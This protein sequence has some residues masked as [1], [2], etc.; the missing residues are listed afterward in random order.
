M[1]TAPPAKIFKK[2]T[3]YALEFK[4][5]KKKEI[6]KNYRKEKRKKINDK[7]VLLYMCNVYVFVY[8]IQQL[9]HIYCMCYWFTS[10]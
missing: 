2:Y 1:Y 6:R 5:E 4:I 10:G 3:I 7:N 8:N 9:V